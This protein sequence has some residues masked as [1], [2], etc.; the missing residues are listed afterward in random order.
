MKTAAVLAVLALQAPGAALPQNA[1]HASHR[2]AAPTSPA[3]SVLA[4]GEVRKVDK[5]AKKLTIRHGPLPALDMP[6]AMTMVY[7]VKEAGILDR[8]K[9]GDR[10]RF[11]AEKVGGLYYVVRVEPAK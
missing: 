5:E 10:V 8:V 4:D 7:A 1:D 11:E 9:A 6:T 2:S 3:A